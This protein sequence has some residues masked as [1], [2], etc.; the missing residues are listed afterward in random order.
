MSVFRMLAAG[1]ARLIT[2]TFTANG[3]IIIPLG[4]S[5]VDM[6]GNGARGTDASSG[7]VSR[8]KITQVIHRYANGEYRRTDTDMGYGYG[9]MPASYCNPVQPT[10]DG[11]V[12][13]CMI[14]TD[15]SYSENRP[16][17][18]GASATALGKTF[19][20]SYGNTTPAVTS[21][22]AVLVTGGTPVTGGTRHNIL[23]PS[24]GS[25]TISYYG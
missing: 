18:T 14:Y 22:S 25:I 8:Y 7:T 6:S 23:V 2:Q 17:T 20:G 4:V 3:T 1:T 5:T 24:G 13:S 21:F 10:S 19:P 11:S 15:A 16:P 12:Q 9:P